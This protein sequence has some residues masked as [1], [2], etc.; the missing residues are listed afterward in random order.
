[1]LSPISTYMTSLREVREGMTAEEFEEGYCQRS[2]ITRE[3]Y[4]LH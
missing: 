4:R 1:M 2:N 3:F